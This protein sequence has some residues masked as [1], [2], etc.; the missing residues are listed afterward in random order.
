MA[1]TRRELSAKLARTSEHSG[2]GLPPAE[3]VEDTPCAITPS[4][5][6]T[7]TD[8][9]AVPAPSPLESLREA[10]NA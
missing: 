10:V 7:P 1:K 9:G 6:F 8:V 4:P 3:C 2:A 5:S